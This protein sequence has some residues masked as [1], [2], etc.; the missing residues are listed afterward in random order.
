MYSEACRRG[1]SGTENV[2]PLEEFV[3]EP[4]KFLDVLGSPTNRTGEEVAA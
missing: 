2:M 3:E 1:S 4:I